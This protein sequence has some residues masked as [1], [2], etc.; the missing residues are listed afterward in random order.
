MVLISAV[1]VYL[2]GLQLALSP[3]TEAEFNK[4]YVR[5]AK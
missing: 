3:C 5:K 4:R 1:S 2:L